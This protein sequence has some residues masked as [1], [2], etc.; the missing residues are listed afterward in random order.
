[1]LDEADAMPEMKVSA[2]AIRLGEIV[3]SMIHTGLEAREWYEATNTNRR[4]PDA[5]QSG[6]V[7][8]IHSA[9]AARQRDL[10]QPF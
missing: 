3:P 4:F 6:L 8:E 10:S 9:M 7:A 2:E 5:W 1:M